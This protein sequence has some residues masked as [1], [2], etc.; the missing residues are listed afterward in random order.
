MTSA[1]TRD[2]LI[3]IGGLALLAAGYYATV[4]RPGRMAVHQAQRGI[5]TAQQSV[6][7]IPH[8]VAELESL[9]QEIERRENFL[10]ASETHVPRRAD[11]HAL[12]GEVTRL[13]EQAGLKVT[14]L[15]PLPQVTHRTYVVAPFHATLSGNFRGLA[16]FL[17]AL[18][19]QE[20]LYAIQDLSITREDARAGGSES[21][22]VHF[23]VYVLREEIPE[24]TNKAD[25]SA[26]AG[27]DSRIR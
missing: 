11:L 7:Q 20:R 2:S 24:F 19:S 26:K 5:A 16:N 13:A 8:R 9:K 22:D 18:E 14:R 27:A 3:T 6:Q 10:R 25:S 17:T 4:Y 1:R 12:V 23:V 21:A 15:E